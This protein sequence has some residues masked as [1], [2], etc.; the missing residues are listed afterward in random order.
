[1][2]IFIMKRIEKNRKIFFA[3]GSVILAV[4][5][6]IIAGIIILRP[7]D[8]IF[9]G[10]AEAD[11]TRISGLLTGRIAKIHVREGDL[12][13]KGDTLVSI[14]SAQAEAKLSQVEAVEQY[15]DAMNQNVDAGARTQQKLALYQVWQK[16]LAAT[17]IAKKTYDRMEALYEDGV[18]SEQKR[19]E[20]KANYQVMVANEKAAHAQ[21]EL[22]VEGAR[23]EEK[24]M[25][26]AGVAQA[27][28]GLEQV[29]AVLA[30]SHLIAPCD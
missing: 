13:N 4:I 19:D 30:D 29:A 14:F 3:F 26:K 8:D 27:K 25:A 11:Y 7:R 18:I 12:V 24:E 6:I 16:A 1:M 10:Q 17:G 9:Q 2:I 28:A 22:A 15:A 20:A 5:I 23:K 21:Y